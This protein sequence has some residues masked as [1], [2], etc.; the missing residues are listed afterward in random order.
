MTTALAFC[1]NTR[2]SR[3][4]LAGT[5]PID[6]PQASLHAAIHRHFGPDT[7]S[8]YWFNRA[9]TLQLNSL[10]EAM[11][12]QLQHPAKTC[13]ESATDLGPSAMTTSAA[14]TRANTAGRAALDE[15]RDQSERAHRCRLHSDCSQ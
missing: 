8:R 9:K 13:P 7:G 14:P 3:I 10:A 5:E 12:D 6:I 2:V 11:V 15:L 4:D 1:A